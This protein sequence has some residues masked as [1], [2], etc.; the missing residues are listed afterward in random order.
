MT[1]EQIYTTFFQCGEL[2]QT[3]SLSRDEARA[4]AEE[5]HIESCACVAVRTMVGRKVLF[6]D[7]YSHFN[8]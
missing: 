8:H 4:E 6:Y 1:P 2:V 7:E 3:V 5:L